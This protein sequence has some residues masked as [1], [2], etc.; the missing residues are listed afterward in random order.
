MVIKRTITIIRIFKFYI[1]FRT[2]NFKHIFSYKI[3]IINGFFI[4]NYGSQGQQR[5][6]IISLKLAECEILSNEKKIA[7]IVFLDD[8]L[9]ELDSK[10]REQLLACLNGKQVFVT[11][12]DKI[13]L[14]TE[15]TSYY[16]M[17]D[18]NLLN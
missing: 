4:K 18:G 11:C 10:R 3:I 14:P 1:R 15:A 13:D 7:P 8:I 5:S 2:I 12:C 16:L 6:S 17:K 9:S